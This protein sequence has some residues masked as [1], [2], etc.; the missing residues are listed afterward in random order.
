M[1]DTEKPTGQRPARHYL[2]LANQFKVHSRLKEVL[3]CVDATTEPRMYEY[4]DSHTDE[5][6]AEEMDF[7]CRATNVRHVREQLFGELRPRARIAPPDSERIASLEKA[8]H[9]LMARVAFL[10]NQLGVENPT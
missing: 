3:V 10:E 8:V 1:S 7:V 4:I 9:V 2:T 5:S 6:V